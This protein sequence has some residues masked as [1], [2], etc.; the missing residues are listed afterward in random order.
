L[1]QFIRGESRVMHGL[2]VMKTRASAHDPHIREFEITS[3]GFVV[4]DQF[5]SEVDL[6]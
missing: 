3:E 2:T 4:G 1:L 6:T 5:S